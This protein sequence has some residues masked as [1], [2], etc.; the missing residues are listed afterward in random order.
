MFIF[1]I[2]FIVYIL[3]RRSQAWMSRWAGNQLITVNPKGLDNDFSHFPQQHNF[4]KSCRKQHIS[5]TKSRTFDKQLIIGSFFIA[6]A[7]F[8]ISTIPD[9]SVYAKY[10]C[11]NGRTLL[12]AHHPYRIHE[13]EGFRH[14]QISGKGKMFS[15]TVLMKELSWF[16]STPAR[17]L[18]EQIS[19]KYLETTQLTYVYKWNW[20][21]K[22]EKKKERKNRPQLNSL[23]E[24]LWEMQ[25]LVI[26]Y[27]N[28]R[29][30]NNWVS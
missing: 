8:F 7:Y 24:N 22:E 10:S 13:V 18:S 27:N 28:L 19:R 5:F 6:S 25:R 14:N 16:V 3:T 11:E 17:Y 29:T 23:M 4:R 9:L 20:S 2:V 30:W 21:T 12:S 26:R 1:D 15:L